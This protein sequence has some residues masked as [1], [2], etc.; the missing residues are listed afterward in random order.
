VEGRRRIPGTWQAQHPRLLASLLACL[1][2]CLQ[3][4]AHTQSSSAVPA[5]VYFLSR[6]SHCPAVVVQP[7]ARH[8]TRNSCSTC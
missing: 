2:Y 3:P 5:P 8:S 4:R 6:Q 7:L 1:A